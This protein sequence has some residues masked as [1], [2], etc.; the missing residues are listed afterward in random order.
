MK[1]LEF[2]LYGSSFKNRVKVD[3]EELHAVADLHIHLDAAQPLT[4]VDIGYWPLP[5]TGAEDQP[6]RLRGYL[7]DTDDPTGRAVAG[8]ILTELLD[9]LPEL[10]LMLG[11]LNI[12]QQDQWLLDLRQWAAKARRAARELVKDS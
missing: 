10:P 8:V 9:Q 2:E 3:G 6:I 12:S 1:R 5:P 7:V 11:S 4:R